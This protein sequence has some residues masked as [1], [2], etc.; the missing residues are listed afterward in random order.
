MNLNILFTAIKLSRNTMVFTF[1]PF[2]TFIIQ[3]SPL[4]KSSLPLSYYLI[5]ETLSKSVLRSQIL[6]V[7]RN[8][9]NRKRIKEHLMSIIRWQY[10]NSIPNKYLLM[11]TL[12]VNTHNFLSCEQ[13]PQYSDWPSVAVTFSWRSVVSAARARH[14]WCVMQCMM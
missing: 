10:C 7:Y 13:H 1:S 4:N 12:Q 14:V 5:L 2:L 11:D 8:G 6:D 3:R 9:G